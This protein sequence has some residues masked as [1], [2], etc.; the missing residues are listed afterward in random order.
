MR[1]GRTAFLKLRPDYFC[2]PVNGCNQRPTRKTLFRKLSS[3]SGGAITTLRIARCSTPPFVPSR[4]IL[5]V[6]TRAARDARRL[7]LR[8]RAEHRAAV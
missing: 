3:S 5:S 2:L 1:I 8:S 7:F 4:S 6:A